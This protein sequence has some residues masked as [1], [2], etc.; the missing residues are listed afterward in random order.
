MSKSDE[1]AFDRVRVKQGINTKTFTPFW[2]VEARLA[3]RKWALMC[4]DNGFKTF[5][6]ECGAQQAADAL[7]EQSEEPQ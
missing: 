1:P 4:D 5:P 7:S 2:Y 6:S 3:P